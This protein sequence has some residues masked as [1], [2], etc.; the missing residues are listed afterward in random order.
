MRCFPALALVLL[1]VSSAHAIGE[2]ATINADRVPVQS[3]IGKI[4]P[5]AYYITGY[6]NKGDRVYV[7][8]EAENGCYPIRPPAG[9]YDLISK[10]EISTPDHRGMAKVKHNNTPVLMGSKFKGPQDNPTRAVRDGLHAG[11]EVFVVG[12]LEGEYYPIKPESSLRYVP[13]EF[14]ALD[15]GAEPLTELRSGSASPSGQS[16]DPMGSDPALDPESARKVQQAEQTYR[17][18]QSNNQLADWA[19]AQQ[20]YEELAK[21]SNP[22]VRL[23]ALNRLEFIRMRNQPS[24]VAGNTNFQTGRYSGATSPTGFHPPGSPPRAGSNYTYAEDSGPARLAPLTQQPPAVPRT[25]QPPAASPPV[26]PPP[27]APPPV[28]AP[29]AVQSPP[30]QARSTPLPPSN[31][32]AKEFG[33]LLRSNRT[34]AGRPLFFLADSRGSLKCYVV[35][36]DAVPLESFVGQNVEIASHGPLTYHTDLRAYMITASQVTL[37]NR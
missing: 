14:V 9:S 25:M 16:F 6:L 32:A 21:N 27:A 8:A 15:A 4:G 1:A 3:G 37:M 12:P 22:D 28:T 20:L 34:E 11:A 33:Q 29:P 30:N 26:A 17:K 18:A 31:T 13:K 24:T 2:N 19:A 35:P 36:T 5:G 23:T 10:H 7:E